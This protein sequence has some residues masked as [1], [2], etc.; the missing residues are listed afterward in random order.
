[1]SHFVGAVALPS[2]LDLDTVLA[3]FNEQPAEAPLHL[4]YTK[5]Q[6]IEKER[7]EIQQYAA[8]TYAAYLADPEGYAANV[9]NPAHLQYLREEFPKRLQFTDEQLFAEA[10]RY[11]NEDTIDVDG[12][13]Y[14]TY[15]KDAHW[16]WYVTGGRW[17]GEYGKD[18]FATM[19]EARTALESAGYPPRVLVDPINGW[20]EKGR[21]GWFGMTSGDSSDEDW[22]REFFARFDEV[23]AAMPSAEVHIV[24]FHI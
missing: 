10:V 18:V 4:L 14:T 21:M 6:A 22:L 19:A 1:M 8:G 16:D 24:D 12:N 5:A 2:L 7:A 3:P 15:P 17:S 13:I 11:E 20:L 23:A 9:N